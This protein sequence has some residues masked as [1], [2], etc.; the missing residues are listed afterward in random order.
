VWLAL[1]LI[2]AVTLGVY[3][4]R[5]K[6][7]SVPTSLPP[8]A[9]DPSKAGIHREMSRL[10]AGWGAYPDCENV[11]NHQASFRV[12]PGLTKVGNSLAAR[13]VGAMSY[14]VATDKARLVALTTTGMSVYDITGGTWTDV[15]DPL[16][17]LTGS[18]ANIGVMRTLESGSSV[19]T[20]A[21]N[22]K[23]APVVWANDP[24]TKYR[25]LGCEV[26][27]TPRCMVVCNNRLVFGNITELSPQ[28]VDY[29]NPLD[30]DNGWGLNETI[31]GDTPGDIVA[32]RELGNLSFVVYKSDA[33]YL[34]QAI[35]ANETFTYQ[36]HS[37]Y[38]AGPVGPQ[39]VLSVG[40][41]L[42]MY[43][44]VDGG[45]Y[46]FDGV[47]PLLLAEYLRTYIAQ[48][49]DRDRMG[50][51]F[52]FIDPETSLAYF[53]YP[54]K[55]SVEIMSA[56]VVDLSTGAAW[57]WRWTTQGF[58]C[59]ISAGLETGVRIGDLPL[60]GNM[61][62]TF[63]E[64]STLN[65]TLLLGGATGQFYSLFGYTDDGAA[66]PFSWAT[67]DSDLGAPTLYK[68][69]TA[70][71]HEFEPTAVSQPVGFQLGTS[72]SSNEPAYEDVQTF[73]LRDPGPYELGHRIAGRKFACR[74]EGSAT[75]PV[76][77]LRSRI[78]AAPGGN[79]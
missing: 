79:R 14:P 77:W 49:L 66:I 71:E 65:P 23:D 53:F 60:I 1:L 2:V 35:A 41:G 54:V 42:H 78:F 36:F 3:L 17:P 61:T 46:K 19:L 29:S 34:A 67:G 69:V 70:S 75:Q 38:N 43:L 20:I 5:R 62:M 8:V 12:R 7:N 11:I 63:G 72:E 21:I 58:S 52:S 47:Q 57:P 56:I 59:G 51:S 6:G 15:T 28:G 10:E 18:A 37:A 16:H 55:G 25:L 31:L 39:A 26:P 76:T 33:I 9:L 30:P 24:A 45:L 68:L 40:E 50:R 32:M 44:A 48:Q 64:L 4:W 73:D 74:F 27:R 22:G 13:V